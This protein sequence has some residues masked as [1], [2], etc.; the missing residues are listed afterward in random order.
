M[1][2]DKGENSKEKREIASIRRV[3]ATVLGGGT[4]KRRKKG[5]QARGRL[6]AGCTH[7]RKYSRIKHSEMANLSYDSSAVRCAS[8]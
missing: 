1:V 6:G 3:Y 4:V 2:S 8:L 7:K 5:D